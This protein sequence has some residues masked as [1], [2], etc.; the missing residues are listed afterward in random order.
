MPKLDGAKMQVHKI[1][2]YVVDFDNVGAEDVKGV[3]EDT[4]YPNR[5]ISPKVLSVESCAIEWHDEHPLNFVYSA[6]DEIERLFSPPP[7]P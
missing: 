7:T 1:T 5:C 3:L 4:R 6:E 2:L